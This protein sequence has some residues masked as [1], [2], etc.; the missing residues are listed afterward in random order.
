ME[1]SFTEQDARLF[2]AGAI[3]PE[4]VYRKKNERY[5]GKRT[6]HCCGNANTTPHHIIP[7][8]EGGLPIFDNIVWLCVPCHDA[9][10]GPSIGARDR[11]MARKNEM[12]KGLSVDV[13][14][15]RDE[16][17]PCGNCGYYLCSHCH[18]EYD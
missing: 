10:E 18:P 2:V 4:K 14:C 16:S 3:A 13:A 12:R 9:V 1:L 15:V 6:C 8:S 7:R 17:L 11:I 5:S